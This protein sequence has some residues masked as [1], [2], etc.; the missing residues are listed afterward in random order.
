MQALV[1]DSN[2]D[3]LSVMDTFQSFIWTIR[4]FEAGDFEL[5]IPA[6]GPAL[7]SMKIG[8]YLWVRDEDR[9]MIIETIQID[10]DLEDGPMAIITGRSLESILDRRIVWKE[11]VLSG[12]FQNGIAQL[13]TEN[14]I[15]PSDPKR[16]IP[17]FR[18]RQTSDSMISSAQIELQLLGDNLYDVIV[19][20][21]REKGFGWRIVPDFGTGGFIFELINGVD[22]SYSQDVVPQVIFSPRYDNFLRSSYV[23]SQK[24]KKNSILIGGGDEKIYE[25][26][27]DDPENPIDTGETYQIFAEESTEQSSGLARRE[28]YLDS[29]H[30]SRNQGY[31]DEIPMDQYI[32][33]L[34][35]AGRS[36]LKEHERAEEFEGEVEYRRQFLYKE[37]FFIGDI[38]QIEN[39]LGMEGRCRITEVV[40]SHDSLGEQLIPTFSKV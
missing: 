24:D 27:P 40:H 25:E 19:S 21:C 13:L 20:A 1:L 22:R 12:S 16:I 39:E 33:S 2:Y 14:V 8:N 10:T 11:T 4:Y 37:D 18:F 31:D 35:E 28:M 36:E 38:V 15:S 17:G 26:N 34:K 23:S 29:S 3:T 5:Y 30:T 6:I 32:S 7:E 9:M